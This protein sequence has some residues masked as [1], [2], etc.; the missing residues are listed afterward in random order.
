MQERV[1]WNPILV[2]IRKPWMNTKI[3]V[4]GRKLFNQ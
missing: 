2:F 1:Q 4:S 3:I